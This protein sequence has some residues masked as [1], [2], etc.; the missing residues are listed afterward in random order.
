MKDITGKTHLKIDTLHCTRQ[1]SMLPHYSGEGSRGNRRLELRGDNKR[2]SARAYLQEI[3]ASILIFLSS[4]LIWAVLVLPL[5]KVSLPFDFSSRILLI[6]FIYFKKMTPQYVWKKKI[7]LYRR[8]CYNVAN[9]QTNNNTVGRRQSRFRDN[10]DST[11]VM[12]CQGQIISVWRKLSTM[13]C[14]IHS[15]LLKNNITW[16]DNISRTEYGWYSSFQIL[17]KG[18]WVTGA[19]IDGVFLTKL[20]AK[21]SIIKKM[22][23]WSSNWFRKL[24]IIG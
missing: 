4:S 10:Y 16:K 21:T 8:F 24:F 6:L 18:D 5:E 2:I 19:H 22:S 20:A 1:V 17:S 12:T 15:K 11:K 3:T 14:I 9:I 7:K 13:T 23:I